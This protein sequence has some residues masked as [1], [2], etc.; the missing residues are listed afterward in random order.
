MT[1]MLTIYYAPGLSVSDFVLEEFYQDVLAKLQQDNVT[2][3]C[4]NEIVRL[5]G[6]IEDL[7]K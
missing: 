2:L 4:S 1:N 6:L 7:E 5:Q 3:A